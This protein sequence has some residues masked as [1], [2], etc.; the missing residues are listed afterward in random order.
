MLSATSLAAVVGVGSGIAGLI[1]GVLAGVF[2]S[3]WRQRKREQR[4]RQLRAIEV[5][6]RGAPRDSS[7]SKYPP[8]VSS[9]AQDEAQS[10][11]PAPKEQIEGRD[12]LDPEHPP[13]PKS[14]AQ[15]KS[16]PSQ[17]ADAQA[18]DND[19]EGH[20]VTKP[21]PT[22]SFWV[23][24][25]P[26]PLEL[27][28]QD[29]CKQLPELMSNSLLRDKIVD[30]QDVVSTQLIGP[31]EHHSPLPKVDRDALVKLLGS[32]DV[33]ELLVL[34]SSDSRNVVSD[35]VKTVLG[36]AVVNRINPRGDPNTTILPPAILSAYREITQHP[37]TEGKHA[38]ISA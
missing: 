31:E 5:R 36:N 32:D 33:D 23:P 37:E 28:G 7:P 14:I 6:N 15:E 21:R 11:H 2:L 16:Q 27:L 38:Y 34:L 18:K 26:Y 10:L 8:R 25:Y 3:Q 9:S 35:A 13:S 19:G 29:I 22:M 30:I 4:T 24:A 17:H 1:I 12:L 20:K